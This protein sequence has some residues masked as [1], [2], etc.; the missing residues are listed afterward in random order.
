M[1]ACQ[2]HELPTDRICQNNPGGKEHVSEKCVFQTSF[3]ILNHVAYLGVFPHLQNLCTN[4]S[5]YVVSFR[6]WL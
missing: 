1:Q 6:D 5:Q 4:F 3:Q 2:I